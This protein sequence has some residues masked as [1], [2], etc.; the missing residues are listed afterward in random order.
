[1]AVYR[2][3][4]S[5]VESI[6]QLSF[7]IFPDSADFGAPTK[8]GDRL[9]NSVKTACEWYGIKSTRVWDSRFHNRGELIQYIYLL[10]EWALSDGRKTEEEATDFFCI[11]YHKIKNGLNLEYDGFFEVTKVKD[12]A[13][14]KL[15]T[16]AEEA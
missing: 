16:K 9:W 8:Q 1:M 15:L 4:Y 12:Q 7:K 2:E 14:I 10:D 3:G 5:A 6:Q 13:I 11:T